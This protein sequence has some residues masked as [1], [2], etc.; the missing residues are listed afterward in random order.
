MGHKYDENSEYTPA[1]AV[2]EIKAKVEDTV[3]IFFD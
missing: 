1:D 3:K 2:V